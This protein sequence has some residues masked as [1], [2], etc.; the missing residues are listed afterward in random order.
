[1]WTKI[2]FFVS[3]GVHHL[4]R[5]TVA[6]GQTYVLIFLADHFSMQ[7]P[8]KNSAFLKGE[9][10]NRVGVE[11]FLTSDPLGVKNPDAPYKNSPFARHRNS[12]SHLQENVCP[13]LNVKI[14]AHSRKMVE[15]K[16]AEAY[17]IFDLKPTI[18]GKEKIE[19]LDLLIDRRDTCYTPCSLYGKNFS[20]TTQKKNCTEL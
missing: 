8:S 6:F 4:L 15:R 16:V 14:L 7:H 12:P 3:R 19:G 17:Y 13:S 9:V 5:Y 1:V 20:P 11:N 18:N 2:L 10:Q